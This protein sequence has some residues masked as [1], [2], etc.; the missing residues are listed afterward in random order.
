MTSDRSGMPGCEKIVPAGT[1]V[2]V[3]VLLVALTLVNILVAQV[4]LRG[5]NTVLGLVIAATQAALSAMFFMHLRWG[6]PLIRL[7]AII[8]L[9]WLAI[10][11]V[12][13]MDDVLTRGWIPVPGK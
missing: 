4:D 5:W 6:R 9:L 7:S 8:G 12:G 3:C 1:Y 13:T 11:I 2:A 10:L